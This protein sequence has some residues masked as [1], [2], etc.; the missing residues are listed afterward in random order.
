MSCSA[1]RIH[2]NR[3]R[4]DGDIPGDACYSVSKER[5]HETGFKDQTKKSKD[6]LPGTV[7]T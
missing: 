3:I 2:R 1:C 4:R 7:V 6:T 5:N